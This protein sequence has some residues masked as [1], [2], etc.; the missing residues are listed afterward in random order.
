MYKS[1]YACFSNENF[2]SRSVII[3]HFT[4]PSPPHHQP[5]QSSV[6]QTQLTATETPVD[7][8]CSERQGFPY[9]GWLQKYCSHSTVL[10]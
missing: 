9:S 3:Y 5:P 2:R 6:I 8:K 4:C 7:L 10:I 1:Y